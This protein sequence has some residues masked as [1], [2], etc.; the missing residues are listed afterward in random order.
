MNADTIV[1]QQPSFLLRGESF[2]LWE[3]GQRRV[4]DHWM[5]HLFRSNAS[6]ILWLESED[7]TLAAY[8]NETFPLCKRA[9]VKAG[10]PATVEEACTFINSAGA[11]QLQ[12]GTE[13][14]SY[15]PTGQPVTKTWFAMVTRWLAELQKFGTQLPELETQVAPGVIIGHHCRI[16]KDTVLH[17]PCWIGN[18]CTISGAVIGPNTAIGEECILSPGTEVS[19]SY[20]LSQSYVPPNIRLDGVIFTQKEVFDHNTGLP[21]IMSMSYP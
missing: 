4:I 12:R 11:I 9:T 10:L 13:P 15:L 7:E 6:M 18:G 19:S 1:H 3:I 14:V 5:D 8:V 20:V 17:A 2:L 16:S 21:A